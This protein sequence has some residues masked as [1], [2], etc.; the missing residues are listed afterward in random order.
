MGDDAAG[1]C[2]LLEGGA[3]SYSAADVIRYLL[4]DASVPTAGS[5]GPTR[6]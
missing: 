4:S 3:D 2:R 5:V 1:V 6:S